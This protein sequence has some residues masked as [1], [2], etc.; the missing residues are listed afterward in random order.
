MASTASAQSRLTRT[1]S[2]LFAFLATQGIL[3]CLGEKD[4]RNQ[5][6]NNINQ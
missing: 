4:S 5:R 2:A 6:K 3:P 1:L